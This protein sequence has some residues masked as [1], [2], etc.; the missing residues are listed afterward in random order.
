M[1]DNDVKPRPSLGGD[2]M[3]LRLMLNLVDIALAAGECAEAM[4]SDFGRDLEATASASRLIERVKLSW[5]GEDARI[6]ETH[7]TSDHTR[8][9][10]ASWHAEVLVEAF[11]IYSHCASIRRL[12]SATAIRNSCR[13]STG[14]FLTVT[15]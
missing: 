14:G 13:G 5:S 3:I 1:R 12:R 10:W 2:S 11:A 15:D 4:R 7:R 8:E 6:E 9:E